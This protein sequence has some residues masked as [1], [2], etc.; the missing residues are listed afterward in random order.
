M[1]IANGLMHE[2]EQASCAIPF[3]WKWTPVRV[4]DCVSFI[5]CEFFFGYSFRYIIITVAIYTNGNA[6]VT[7]KHMKPIHAQFIRSLSLFR[8]VWCMHS[9]IHTRKLFDIVCYSL[10]TISRL[11]DGSGDTGTVR[12]FYASWIGCSYMYVCVNRLWVYWFILLDSFSF[13]P[14]N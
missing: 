13:Y 8:F 3:I 2:I 1:H 14:F 5:I 6:C 4:F 11:F 7:D 10:S 9:Y 12:P